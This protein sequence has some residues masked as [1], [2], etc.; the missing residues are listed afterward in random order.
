[1]LKII[2]GRISS[3]KTHIIV[4]EI[5]KRISL[6]KKS[7]LIV[8]DPVTYNFEQRLCS[9]LNINGFI[10]VEVCSF[11]RLA[12]SIIDYFGQ[13]KKS[14]LDESTKAM[15][16]RFCILN[17]KDRLTIFK[18][19]SDKKGFSAL[20]LKMIATLENCGYSIEDLNK[21]INKL[22]D[23]ILK[24]KLNDMSVLYEEY[25]K[26]LESGYTDNADKLKT[27]Q[28]LLP[29]YSE[30]KDTAVFIDGFDI[31][32]TSLYNF[33]GSLLAQTDVTIAL[34]SAEN[35]T[36]S[37]AYEIQQ[38]TLDTLI[39]IAKDQNVPHVIEHVINKS[40]NKNSA[41]HFLEDNFYKT[42]PDKFT[43]ETDGITLEY[44]SSP[45]DEIEAVARK[46]S[47]GIKNGNRFKNYAVLCNDVNKYAPLINTVFTRY[48]I[49]VHTDRKYDINAH[50]VS[51]YLFAIL[52]CA[53]S[54]F[55]ADNILDI[56]LSSLTDLNQY[57]KDLFV[58][59]IKEMGVKGYEIENG[60]YY[61][62]GN[63]KKQTEFDII[64]KK[65]VEPIKEFRANILQKQTA[66]E[67]AACCYEFLE[68]QHIYY[69]IQRLVDKYEELEFFALSDITAQL[70]NKTQQLLE[71]LAQLASNEAITVE[72]FTNILLEGFNSTSA[73]TIPSVLDC[74]TFGDLSSAKEQDIPY[75]FIV[76]ANDGIIPAIYTDER[77]VTAS[78]SALL[79]ELG[80]EL[81]HSVET[82]DAR[83]R[84]NI[85]SAICTPTKNLTFSCPLFN[86]NGSPLRPSPIFK[87][88]L[89]LFPNIKIIN[90]PALTPQQK[91]QDLY[92]VDEALNNMA[93]DRL[94]SP[95]AQALSEYF[96][97][98]QN[99]KFK[100]LK[101]ESAEKTNVL[102][103][104]IASE[105]FLPK[106]YTSISRLETYANCPF[107]HFIRYGLLPEEAKEY[108]TNALDI[109]TMIHS[110]LEIFTK[111][112][113]SKEMTQD[114]CFKKT[115]EIF[116]K[117]VPDIHFGAMLSSD[118]QKAFNKILKDLTCQSAWKIKEHLQEFSV[119]GE[120]IAFGYGKYP[121]IEIN[122]EYGTLYIKGK[123]DRADK[124]E[125]DGKVFLRIV[126]YKSGEKKFNPSNVEKG[127]DIQ[128]MIYMNALLSHFE[129][130]SP[131]S[132]QYMLIAKDN[133]FSGPLNNSIFNDKKALSEEEF[134]SLIDNA[135]KT[136]VNLTED[137]LSGNIMP[138]ECDNCKYC[139][140]SSI[141]GI[142]SI[143]KE[144]GFNA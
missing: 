113:E 142:K 39:K 88:F 34:S 94:T 102:P 86:I 122:T 65:F 23:G 141:C 2:A 79:L 131:A 78:E 49:P 33:I 108:S 63:E 37:N 135:K 119:I 36:D 99:K 60:L 50:P 21:V 74:V 126:D 125:K 4:E 139:E 52:K 143:N 73:S 31:F 26:I 30:I 137:M 100:I 107:K 48:N 57:Q 38:S 127:T 32:T 118:R 121:P 28:N 109:G 68:N 9:Q 140:Y 87:R 55:S 138:R 82:E 132:A 40:K 14:Y 47:D 144:D 56:A 24:Y 105:L 12:S 133:E 62:R 93:L 13:N 97:K 85:Y 18:S 134:Y 59:F 104:E 90:C 41:I 128:L 106:S 15:A 129:N 61:D 22:D 29:L 115:S 124:L 112:N 11:N 69:K 71:D 92:T 101:E 19:A 45:Q 117:I 42:K 120:E 81:A 95:E 89:Q 20:A 1:M 17:A 103:K 3:S 91:L 46:I 114:E 53:Y 51:M 76:G 27:A 25:N 130:S 66:K 98:N 43:E 84:Y 111:E 35:G 75:V 77:I 6:R 70:W 80:L 8:P 64:R 110:T 96:T 16:M 123:I 10:D 136:A 83:L 67:M 58:S 7:I 54:G 5:G 72:Q 44:Y 116:D